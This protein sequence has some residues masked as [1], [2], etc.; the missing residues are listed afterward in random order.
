M[1]L[2]GDVGCDEGAA[3]KVAEAIVGLFRG[4]GRQRVAVVDG[5]E[6]DSQVGVKARVG[7]DGNGRARAAS[8]VADEVSAH[9][10]GRGAA[11]E[12]IVDAMDEKTNDDVFG[13]VFKVGIILLDV[14]LQIRDERRVFG[15]L[16]DHILDIILNILWK[17]K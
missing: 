7:E 1:S 11:K 2:A 15:L 3:R 17:H 5:V 8:R 10:G 16:I 9:G 13:D 4:R 6:K 12:L 14:A